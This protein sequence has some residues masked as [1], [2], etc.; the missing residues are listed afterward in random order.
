ME[1]NLEE[2]LLASEIP[3]HLDMSQRQLERLFKLHT[4]VTPKRYYLNMRLDRARGLVTQTELSIAEV[5]G[6]CGFASAEQMTRAYKQ[7]F[8]ITPSTDRIQGRIP[9]QYRSFPQYSG[10]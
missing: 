6:A 8:K 7:N 9:F 2:P 3:R 10:V 1:R 5:A 4:N